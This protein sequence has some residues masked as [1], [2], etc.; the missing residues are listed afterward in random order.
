MSWSVTGENTTGPYVKYEG[1]APSRLGMSLGLRGGTG[2]CTVSSRP[3][4]RIVSGT[5][6]SFASFWTR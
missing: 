3:P 2:T 5:L 1:Y 6:P 4:R